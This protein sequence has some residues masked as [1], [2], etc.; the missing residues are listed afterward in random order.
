MHCEVTKSGTEAL[1][2]LCQRQHEGH[3]FDIAIIDQH[4]P[5][6]SHNDG[7]SLGRAIRQDPD[8]SNIRLILMTSLA[9][10]GEGRL[11]KEAG[12]YG[13][14]TK[15]VRHDQLLHCMQLVMGTAIPTSPSEVDVSPNLITRHTIEKT[16]SRSQIRILL[17]EDN[18]VNQKVAVRMLDKLGYRVDVVT[19]GV[20][21][22]EALR[23]TPYDLVLM[24]CHMPEMDGYTTTKLIREQEQEQQQRLEGTKQDL[25]ESLSIKGSPSESSSPP[26]LPII[27]L[28]ANALQGDRE[29]CLEAGMDDFLP[30][31]ISVEELDKTLKRWV[32][33]PLSRSMLQPS[34]NNSPQVPASVPTRSETL[35]RDSS[36]LDG[37]TL[38]ELQALGGD[39]EP[40]FLYTLFDQFLTDGPRHIY[41]IQQA[42]I[43]QNPVILAKAAHS[44]K[45]SSR[46]IGAF[47]LAEACLALENLGCTGTTEGAEELLEHVQQELERVTVALKGLLETSQT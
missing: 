30:K 18:L 25:K 7:L 16:Q 2:L 21:A 15:P 38:Q 26:H 28:T 29:I 8:L 44:C 41:A 34:P 12:F 36:P 17:A 32:S 27:A 9:Q 40:D 11:A 24:D 1:H 33:A 13:Y 22:L 20:E 43:D 45:G 31:P 35:G 5:Q 3:P 46:Y 4:S 37:A 19:N 47:L 42:I 39:D 23:R 14:L 6:P 10:R